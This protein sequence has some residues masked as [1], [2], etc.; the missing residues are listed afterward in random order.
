MRQDIA[1]QLK[2]LL[3]EEKINMVLIS[4]YYNNT[5]IDLTDKVIKLVKE[6]KQ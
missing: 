1:V 4:Y 6:I 5:G 2:K 3:K